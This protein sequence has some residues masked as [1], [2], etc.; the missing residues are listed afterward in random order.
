MV[1]G[2]GLVGIKIRVGRKIDLD[3]GGG[4]LV[5]V[6]RQIL[7]RARRD[8]PEF[9]GGGAKSNAGMKQHQID[10]WS[11][12]S[13]TIGHSPSTRVE[14]SSQILV[15]IL[16]M[17]QRAGEFQFHLAEHVTDAVVRVDRRPQRYNV[18]HHSAGPSGSLC[19][20]SG[21]G[22]TQDHISGADRAGQERGQGSDHY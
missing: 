6:D 2:E 4:R 8:H 7:H 11:V 22:Q 5:D 12:K 20:A 3:V 19:R 17:T 9:T 13:S 15:P 14:I 10:Q 21:H 1:G 18:R 16:L